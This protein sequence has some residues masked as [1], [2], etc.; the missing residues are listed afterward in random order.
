[1]S[2]STCFVC[3]SSLAFS[4]GAGIDTNLIEV[5]SVPLPTK[6]DAF[7]HPQGQPRTRAPQSQGSLTSCRLP[8]REGC[9]G[10]AM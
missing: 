5:P 8:H 4:S 1:M 7:F 10:R 2:V 6:R 9:L 3:D